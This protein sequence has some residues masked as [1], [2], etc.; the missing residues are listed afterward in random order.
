MTTQ[1]TPTTSQPVL[2]EGP[3]WKL[4]Y[5]Q[6]E[7]GG[8]GFAFFEMQ[9]PNGEAIWYTPESIAERLAW[10]DERVSAL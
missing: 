5:K 9:Q 2:A 7:E 6:F 4:I 3:G 1:Q 10:W 8:P